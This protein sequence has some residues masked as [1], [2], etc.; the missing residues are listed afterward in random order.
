M[1]GRERASRGIRTPGPGDGGFSLVEV[2]VAMT[3]LVIVSLATF[4]VL[5]TSLSAVRGNNDRVQAASIART[6]LE[7]L[8][9]LGA[10]GIPP[11]LSTP[12]Y[13]ATGFA[14]ETTANWVGVDQDTNP[15][16]SAAGGSPGQAYM[17]VHIEVTGGELTAPQVIDAL[18]PPLDDVPAVLAGSVTAWVRDQQATPQPVSGITVTAT[19]SSVGATPQAAVTGYDGCVF[20]ADLVPGSWTVSIGVTPPGMVRPGT[21]AT[22]A[23]ANLAVGQNVPLSFY[24]APSTSIAFAAGSERYDLLA[25]IPFRGGFGT[26]A[27]T[28]PATMPGA[29]FTIPAGTD[30]LLWPD[31]SG[32]TARLGCDDVGSPVVIAVQPGSTTTIQLPAKEVEIV[33]PRGEQ[34]TVSHEIEPSPSPCDEGLSLAGGNLSAPGDPDQPDAV[35]GATGRERV[36]VPLG[37]WTFTVPGEDP[38]TVTFTDATPS[39]CSV[40]WPP[41]VEPTPT[42][43]PTP[44]PSPAPS[45][46][47]PP[48]A[49]PEPSP[50]VTLPA[51]EPEAEPCAG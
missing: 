17:R 44:P 51:L 4:G 29:G 42:P 2:I 35:L 48:S 26:W 27:G 21:S 8:R 45:E 49:S 31:A 34:V 33:G 18:V 14:V 47:P 12:D 38:I 46:F 25:D 37:T 24:T 43:A 9:T 32:Y 19:S 23:V 30:P 28:V 39:P 36:S 40:Y 1:S 16:E 41:A 22:T 20:F 7:R 6:E 3:V 10:A 15:C 5:M 11:G 50:I 13:A